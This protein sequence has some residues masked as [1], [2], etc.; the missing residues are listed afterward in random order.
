MFR[1]HS[2]LCCLLSDHPV[3][4]L[5]FAPLAA[6]YTNTTAGHPTRW[7]YQHNVPD[8]C[9]LSVV[10]WVI[11]WIHEAIAGTTVAPTIDSCIHPIMV[12]STR[13]GSIPLA[14]F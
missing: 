10:R 8:A 13:Q 7:H 9:R 3:R 4:P 6:A 11:R 5:C 14:P 12:T 2:G 1:L